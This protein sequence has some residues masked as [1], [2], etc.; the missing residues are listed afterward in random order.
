MPPRKRTRKGEAVQ[1]DEVQPPPGLDRASD[2]DMG[3]TAAPQPSQRRSASR[4]GK[5]PVDVGGRA[6]GAHLPPAQDHALS[7]V[8]LADW[9]DAQHDEMLHSGRGPSSTSIMN[10]MAEAVVKV[11]CVHCQSNFSLPWQRRRQF[12]ST[13]S[14]FIVPGNRILTNAHCVEHAASLKV[15]RRGSDEK[16][17]ADVVATGAE[18]DIAMLKVEDPSFFEGVKPVQFGDLPNLQ[19]SCIVVGYPIGGDTMSVTSGV[20]SRI[21][22]TSY[23]HGSTELLGIQI[24]AAINSGNSGGPA[25][26]DRGQCVGI[27]FQSLK[28]ADDAENIGYI[29][30]SMQCA[31]GFTILNL[32]YS[33]YSMLSRKSPFVRIQ[34]FKKYRA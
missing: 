25:F 24:D 34:V 11:F 23:V 17:I 15:K 26:N 27:A 22:V 20:V 30:V 7:P 14:G 29:I 13:S 2:E 31:V 18:C 16:F 32:I 1:E 19:D 3:Y 6:P 9:E 12:S 33:L 8:E 4:R 21:E 10:E 28:G 5:A